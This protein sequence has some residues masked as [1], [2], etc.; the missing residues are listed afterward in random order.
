MTGHSL[1]T[2]CGVGRDRERLGNAGMIQAFIMVYSAAF[3]HPEPRSPRNPADKKEF[4]KI[5]S[6]HERYRLLRKATMMRTTLAVLMAAISATASGAEPGPLAFRP[7][8]DEGYVAFDTGLLRGKVRLDGKH[9][10]VSSIV[11]ASTNMELAKS[12][13]LLSYYRV[14]S[15]GKRYGHAARDW[16]LET[17]L[18]DDGA[19]QIVF[20]P[21]EEHPLEMTGTFRWRAPDT[22]DLETTVTPHVP[23]PRMEVFLSSYLIEEFEGLVYLQPNRYAKG[24]TPAFVRTDWSELIGGNYLMFPRDPDVLPMIYDGR[25]EFPPSPVTWAFTRYLAA[26]IGIRRHAQA[27]LTVVLMSPPADCFAVAVPYNREPP[28]NVASHGSV[29]LSLFGADLAAGQTATAH[30]RLI[31]AKDLSDEAILQR[32]RAYLEERGPRPQ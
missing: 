16:P 10:G 5:C 29:Y 11:H 22:L 32:Y 2:A 7:A 24:E 9:Q 27:G 13:G 20:P 14:F 26:P 25:W 18:L 31:I 3:D 12:V 1:L 21:H 19:L 28:D 8:D 4:P 6:R 17:K 30:C 23:M 15:A